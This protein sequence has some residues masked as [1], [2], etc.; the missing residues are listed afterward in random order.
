[1]TEKKLRSTVI[2][3]NKHN[4][5]FFKRLETQLGGGWK[6]K[7]INKKESIVTGSSSYAISL[8]IEN[9]GYRAEIPI[10]RFMDVPVALTRKEFKERADGVC[11]LL[12]TR[13]IIQEFKEGYDKIFSIEEMADELRDNLTHQSKGI[14]PLRR[15]KI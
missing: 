12:R 4:K 8:V 9:E 5:N 2:A 7:Y 10:I 1:M 15:T 3:V 6:L 14:K 11:K 13:K